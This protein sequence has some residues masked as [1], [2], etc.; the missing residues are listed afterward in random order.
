VNKRKQIR[1]LHM[2]H[3]LGFQLDTPLNYNFAVGLRDMISFSIS[4]YMEDII[5]R[6]LRDE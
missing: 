3:Y 6:S 5:Y 1:T 4:N 2:W